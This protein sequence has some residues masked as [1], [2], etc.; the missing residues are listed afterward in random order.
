ME[1]KGLKIGNDIFISLDMTWNKYP[2]SQPKQTLN[3]STATI[4]LEYNF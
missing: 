2:I 3:A 1:K 4:S